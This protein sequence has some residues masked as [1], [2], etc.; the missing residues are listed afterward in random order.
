LKDII[1]QEIPTFE[2]RTDYLICKDKDNTLHITFTTNYDQTLK[3]SSIIREN[4]S[5]LLSEENLRRKVVNG[6]RI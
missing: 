4:W 5:L 6:P 3:T 2:E 1:R